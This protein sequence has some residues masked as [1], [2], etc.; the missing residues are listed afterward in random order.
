MNQG[1]PVRWTC[2][3]AG[4]AGI[5]GVLMIG[6]SFA[7]NNGPP[8]SAPD[9]VFLAYAA[10]HRAPVLWG[11]W[12]QAVGPGL[13][14]TLALTLV[15]LS[16]AYRRVSGLLTVFGAGVLMT[17]SLMEIACYIGQLFVVP[18]EMPRIANTFGYAI[19]HLYFFVAAPALFLPLGF[20]LVSSSVLPRIF[21]WLALLLGAGFL[22]LGLV[23][24]EDLVLPSGVTAFAA[25]QALWWFFAALALIFRSGRLARE[26]APSRSDPVARTA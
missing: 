24:L 22:A 2:V 5:V 13:I 17:T 20:V 8:L 26:A 21:G 7:I 12:L 6:E 4:V 16:G 18:P 11:A 3:L 14:I 10:S 1:L 23:S 15:G 19:Q 25:V 9:A